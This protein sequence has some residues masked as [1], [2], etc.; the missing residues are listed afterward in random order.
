[1]FHPVFAVGPFPFALSFTFF[2]TFAFAL[3]FAF[4]FFSVQSCGWNHDWLGL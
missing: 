2:F 3:V 4:A 1:M